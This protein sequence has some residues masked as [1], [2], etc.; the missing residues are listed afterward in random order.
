MD[1]EPNLEK[2]IEF[3]MKRAQ[4]ISIIEGPNMMDKKSKVSEPGAKKR[5]TACPRCCGNHYL[6]R[7]EQFRALK[8]LAKLETL[9][10]ANICGNCFSSSHS[11]NNCPGGPCNRCAPIKHNSLL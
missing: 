4:S 1:Q 10:D 8:L 9:R 2:M 3:L 6:H 7:C 11:I 5:K